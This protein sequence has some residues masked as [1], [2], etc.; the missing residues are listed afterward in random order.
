MGPDRGRRRSFLMLAATLLAVAYA[1]LRYYWPSLTGDL[2]VDAFLGIVLG[3]YVCSL[4]AANLLD[5]LLFRRHSAPPFHSVGS[6]LIWIA[7]NV[8]VLLLGW[9]DLFLGATELASRA[10]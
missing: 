4:P 9:M 1:L 10:S 7:L 2:R 8:T 5:L 3:L 6:L